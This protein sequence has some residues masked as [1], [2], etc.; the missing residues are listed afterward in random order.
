[1]RARI[2][3]CAVAALAGWAPQARALPPAGPSLCQTRVE[4]PAARLIPRLSRGVNL[5][6]WLDGERPR[7]FS[8]E[9]LRRLRRLGFDH[10]RLPFDGERVMPSFEAGRAGQSLDELDQALDALE[11]AEFLV[12]LD[13]HPGARFQALARIAPQSAEADLSA[14]WTRLSTRLKRRPNDGLIYELLNEPTAAPEIWAGQ[15]ARL[16]KDLRAREPRRTLMIGEAGFERVDDLTR[17]LPAPDDNV[18]YAAHF[19]DPFPFTHQGM[20][21]D[22]SD[23]LS[24]ARG[25]PFPLT[26]ERLA[27]GGAAARARQAGDVKLADDLDRMAAMRL[28][29]AAVARELAKLGD[30]A[31]RARRRVVIGEFGVIRGAAPL[32]DRLAWLQAVRKGAEDACLGWTLWESRDAFGFLSADG[33]PDPEVV[34]AL[35]DP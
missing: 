27:A 17:A 12:V 15:R 33:T 29:A 28:D 3:L 32:A 10:V 30:W 31:T 9:T 25:V 5:A 7:P 23:P 22:P 35:F 18:V 20:F 16:I 26:P 13:L 6:G 8:D 19:Y 21:W 34:K 1:M 24:R 14:A 11:R 4:G 2:F